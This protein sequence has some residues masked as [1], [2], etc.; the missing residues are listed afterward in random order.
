MAAFTF[1]LGLESGFMNFVLALRVSGYEP[2]NSQ[3]FCIFTRH[4]V[5]R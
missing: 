5:E 1:P 4:R 2:E 3:R